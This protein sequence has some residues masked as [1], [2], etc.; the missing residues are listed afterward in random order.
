MPDSNGKPL[1]PLED[2][3]LGY[4]ETAEIRFTRC[5]HKNTKLVSGIELR[6]TCGANWHGQDVRQLQKLFNQ[7]S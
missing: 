7:S 6:C 3:P 2:D 4:K 5:P 1:P